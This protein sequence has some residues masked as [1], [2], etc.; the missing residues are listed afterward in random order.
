MRLMV[1]ILNDTIDTIPPWYIHVTVVYMYNYI[2]F[3]ITLH[4]ITVHYIA[5]H[6]IT[7]HYITLHCS[8]SQNSTEQYTPH[9]LPLYI[10]M[11]FTTIIFI[12]YT[13]IAF[14]VSVVYTVTQENAINSIL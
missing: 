13:T 2:I 10:Y 5:V 9:I 11:H 14:R 6:Y 4:Y 12:C 8:T 1:D 7:L 3:H